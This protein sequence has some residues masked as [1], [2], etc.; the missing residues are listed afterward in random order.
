M[1]RLD[2]HPEPYTP[3]KDEGRRTGAL[4]GLF[5]R[6]AE[7]HQTQNQAEIFEIRG[8]R[9]VGSPIH[10]HGS[11]IE[12]FYV[13]EGELTYRLGERE[14]QVAA[15]AFVMVPPKARHALVVESEEARFLSLAVPGGLAKSFDEVGQPAGT[16]ALPAASLPMPDPSVLMAAAERSDQII[17]GPPLQPRKPL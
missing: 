12:C 13:L 16:A 17:L 7:A 3:P 6:K 9:G 14:V 5:T 15:G 8:R 1:T 10:A 4:G 2:P 11:Q